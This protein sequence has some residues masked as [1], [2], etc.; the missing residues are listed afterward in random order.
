MAHATDIEKRNRAVIAFAL[1]T[2]ARDDAIASLSL[3]HVD[4]PRA[5]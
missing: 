4:L 1:L 3:R 5:W 2:G